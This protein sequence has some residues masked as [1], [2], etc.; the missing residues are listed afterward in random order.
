[1]RVLFSFYFQNYCYYAQFIIKYYYIFLI[2][3]F[4]KY[5]YIT[6]LLCYTMM[7]IIISITVYLINF[8]LRVD[9]NEK[10]C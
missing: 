1:M 10:L 3:F 4:I 8:F 7:S 2:Y 9:D 6:L 5:L